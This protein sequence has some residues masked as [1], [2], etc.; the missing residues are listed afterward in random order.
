LRRKRLFGTRGIRGPI[1][2]KVKPE[3]LLG[4]G[5]ALGDYVK[6]GMVVVGR[7]TR[8]SGEMLARAF[9][10]GLLAA[11][12]DVV[13]IGVAPSPCVAFTTLELGAAA[14]AVITA[15]HNPPPD[16]GIT[17][18]HADG[19]EFRPEDEI[20]LEERVLDREPQ[21]ASWDSLGVIQRYD[22][23]RPYIDG[24]KNQVKLARGLKVVID[25][26]NGAASP[27]TPILL[28]ELGCKVTT[29]NSHPDGY[30]PGRPSEPQPWNLGDLMKTVKEIGADLGIAHDGD[31][32]RVAAVDENGKFIK[33]DALI[34]LFAEQVVRSRGGGTVVA[35]VNTSAAIEEVVARAGGRI[36]RTGLGMF[37]EEMLKHD[38][39]FAGEPGK[40]VFQDVRPWADGPYVAAKL[41][42]ILAA[43]NKPTSRVFAERVPDYLMYHEDFQCPDELKRPFMDLMKKVVMERAGDVKELIE[44]DGLRINRKNGSWVLVR[45]SGTEPKARVV[46][47]GRTPEELEQLKNIAFVEARKFFER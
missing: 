16:N 25:C 7:D 37:T 12:S 35:S 22:S 31:A 10:S 1:A 6:K 20:A 39:C 17:F 9:T 18:Y 45:V 14:G 28:R 11:G 46:V 4:L 19:T 15:S 34:A 27:V 32:D 47:E 42:E 30:F 21:R 13:D 44:V 40:L 24:I 29:I 8:I 5:L 23:I 41:I 2:T 36:I 3:L 38:A 26:S 43:E 33:H